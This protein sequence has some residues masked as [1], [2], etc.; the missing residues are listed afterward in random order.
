MIIRGDRFHSAYDMRQILLFTGA[1]LLSWPAWAQDF[2]GLHAGITAA[3]GFGTTDSTFGLIND[4]AIDPTPNPAS[5]L[6]CRSR[7]L[8]GRAADGRR[9]PGRS[10]RAG[11]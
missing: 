7:G 8:S 11:G 9:R 6:P 4:D 2:D 3:A 5:V 10:L 1:A